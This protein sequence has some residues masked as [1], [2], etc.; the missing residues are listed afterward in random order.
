MYPGQ[1]LQYQPGFASPIDEFQ[2]VLKKAQECT[3]SVLELGTK[4]SQPN[5]PTHHKAF[6]PE[7]SRYIMTDF[8]E[9][10]DVDV[11]ADAHSLTTTFGFQ[12]F[13]FVW[14]SSVF[15][16][17][18]RPWEAAEEIIRV[19]KPGGYVFIQ[20]HFAFPWHGYP[21]DYFRFT[22]DGLISCFRGLEEKKGWMEFPA[23]IISQ[24]DPTSA[25]APAFLNSCL[26]GRRL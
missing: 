7:A 11:V 22:H 26:F 15:E 14:A 18:E 20:T 2:E 24:E 17:L 9:G 21:N 3:G 13:D 5:R 1:N 19:L 4:R 8:Q 25:S 6:F 16:H 12:V 23:R 10:L